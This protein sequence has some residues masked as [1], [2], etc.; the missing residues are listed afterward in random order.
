MAQQSGLSGSPA[1]LALE[2]Q[3]VRGENDQRRRALGEI[4]VANALQGIQNLQTGAGMELNR[5]TS[6]AQMANQVALQN[7]F[8]ILQAMNQN[9][10]NLQQTNMLNTQNRQ[11]QQMTQ[12]GNQ[13]Q[14]YGQ[15]AQTYNTGMLN[16]STQADVFNA[17]QQ[18]QRGLNQ[19]NLDRGADVFN[20]GN[21]MQ[22]YGW[23]TSN[24]VNLAN[25]T[26]ANNLY[27]QGAG[28]TGALDFGSPW[29]NLLTLNGG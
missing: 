22:R 19:A 3:A 16:R 9:V 17:G 14:L 13:S 24:L 5:Q 4:E 6:G 8:N 15:G 12:A 21:Q 26:G 29:G 20:V 1:G 23:D 27:S 2:Q 25:Q 28:L 11:D 18:T 7:T 10:A